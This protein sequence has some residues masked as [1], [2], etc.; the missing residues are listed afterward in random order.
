MQVLDGDRLLL[1]PDPVALL[2]RKPSALILPP[3][4]HAPVVPDN[5]RGSQD[6]NPDGMYDVNLDLIR[7]AVPRALDFQ[8]MQV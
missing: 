1:N 7:P 6:G 2:A 8:S 5:P 3:H 4:Y